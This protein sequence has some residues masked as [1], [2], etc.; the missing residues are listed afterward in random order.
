MFICYDITIN[1]LD[2]F[3]Y[4]L[5]KPIILTNKQFYKIKKSKYYKIRL[6]QNLKVLKCHFNEKRCYKILVE[7]ILKNKK[8][9]IGKR[10]QS[11][12]KYK[13]DFNISF[14]NN[15]HY[16][17]WEFILFDISNNIMELKNKRICFNIHYRCNCDNSIIQSNNTSENYFINLNR[18]YP[19]SFRLLL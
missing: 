16:I 17:L 15:K 3:S 18:F 19:H 2:Y 7:D 14:C 13:K 12:L 5:L 6:L 11:I 9:Y 8:K 10:F 4:S 1:I